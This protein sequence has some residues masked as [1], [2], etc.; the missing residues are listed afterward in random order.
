VIWPIAI[1]PTGPLNN[2]ETKNLHPQTNNADLKPSIE[3]AIITT[4]SDKS[5]LSHGAK[6]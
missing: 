1:G 2:I 4:I 3:I 5:K 6:G